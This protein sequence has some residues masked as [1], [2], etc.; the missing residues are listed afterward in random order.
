MQ[1]LR[2]MIG[3]GTDALE[4]SKSALAGWQKEVSCLKHVDGALSRTGVQSFIL[5]GVLGE[6]QVC[7]TPCN[8]AIGSCLS[9]A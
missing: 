6:L 5:E 1:G 8:K 9:D 4:L 7:Q 3:E 2:E